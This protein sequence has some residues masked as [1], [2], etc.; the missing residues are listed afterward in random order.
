MCLPVSSGSAST[1]PLWLGFPDPLIEP[2]VRFS[3]IRLSD[4]VSRQRVRK[5]GR[6]GPA[7]GF[8]AENRPSYALGAVQ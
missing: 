5:L 2:D 7:R 3:R 6:R 4:W 8:R 1:S